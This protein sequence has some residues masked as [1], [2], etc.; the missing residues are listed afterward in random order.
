[1]I[2][3]AGRPYG[4]DDAES[5]DRLERIIIELM[6]RASA[7]YSF[8]TE[9]GLQ[10][11]INLRKNIVQS[12]ESMSKSDV[13]FATFETTRSNPQYWVLTNYGALHLRPGVQPADAVEDIYVNSGQYAFECAGAMLIIYYHA[14]LQV[15]GA[16]TFNFLF[17]DLYI[18]SWHA[19]SDL[20]L[21]PLNTRN[22]LPGDVVYFD[23]P[24]FD[25]S[26]P[27]WRG[28]NAVAMGEY[29]YFGHGLGV[30]SE[31]QMVETLNELRRP[32]A[33][34]S[35][36]LTNLVV[37]P[38][39]SHLQQFAVRGQSEFVR[40]YQPALILHN[41]SSIPYERYR[42]YMNKVFKQLF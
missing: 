28:E 8:P 3:V 22:Y 41:E 33:Y 4:I 29:L 25:P 35:S 12:A 17:P 6:S 1:M 30:L 19:D 27:Q 40:K 13:S 42:Y 9:Q 2:Q 39:F 37:R 36:Y 23:N 21:Y 11:E 15:L 24:D 10:F 26:A 38:T 31:K 14:V 18:Y 34:T 32:G 7:V 20:G 5:P 16:R